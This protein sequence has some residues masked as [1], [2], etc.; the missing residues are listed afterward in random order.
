MKRDLVCEVSPELYP[1]IEGTTDS[2]VMF[3]LALTL[4]LEEDP[5][6]AAARMAHLVERVG[7]EHGVEE[8]LTMTLGISDGNRLYGI[9]YA[10]DGSPRTLFHS[11]DMSALRGLNP[12]VERFSDHARAVVSEPF[13]TLSESWVEIP[14]S[15]AVIVDRGTLETRE[16]RPRAE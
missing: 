6:A 5:L 7:R 13:G 10:T 12:R 14:P 2:E 3:F 8:A 9:R 16:F 11:R 15:S 1:S 4:G